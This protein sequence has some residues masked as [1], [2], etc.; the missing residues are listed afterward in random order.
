[1]RKWPTMPLLESGQREP[2]DRRP[3]ATV[4][5]AAGGPLV[6][7]LSQTLPDGLGRKR[8]LWTFAVPWPAKR[9]N[10]RTGSDRADGLYFTGG[11]ARSVQVGRASGADTSLD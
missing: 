10:A 1:M 4:R 2:R 7:W 8:H 5:S 3:A 11:Q 6:T 9:R